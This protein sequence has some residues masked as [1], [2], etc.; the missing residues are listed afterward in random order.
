M[1]CDDGVNK[2]LEYYKKSLNV[3]L[4]LFGENHLSV[5]CDYKRIGKFYT[6]FRADGKKGL[7]YYEK[8]L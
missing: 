3:K 1:Q 4:S 5:A 6:D 7:E 8:A 2:A